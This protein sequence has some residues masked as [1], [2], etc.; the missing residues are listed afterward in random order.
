MTNNSVNK[1]YFKWLC[2]IVCEGR[3]SSGVTYHKLLEY[4]HDTEFTYSLPMDGNR[5]D[6]GLNLRYRFAYKHTDIEC[7]EDYIYGECSVLE[8]MVALAI[9][10]EEDYMD[11]GEI[12]D[13]TSQWFWG[14]INNLG[15]GDMYDQL[16]DEYRVA[17]VIDRFLDRRYDP[18]GRGG[19]FRIRNCEDDLRGVE[20]WYQ[21]QWYLNSIT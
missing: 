10:C 13:R 9:R 15:L 6:D 21:L 4:L 5:A 1:S 16:F 3:Y 20:I 12:G 17:S 2:D 18:D 11:D 14:M 19:L 7:I 8:M